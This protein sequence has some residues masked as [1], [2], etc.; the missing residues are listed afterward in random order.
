[1][2]TLSLLIPLYFLLSTS[3]SPMDD[4]TLTIKKTEDFEVS[5]EGKAQAWQ[6][7]DWI[8]IPQRE[9]QNDGWKTQAKI[10]YSD[11]GIYFLM[12]CEDSILTATLEEDFTNLYNEDV[13]EV[14]LWTDESHPVYFEYEISPLNY[15]LPIMVPNLGDDFFGWLPWHYE[16]ERKTRHATSVQGGEKKSGAT[17][18]GWTAEFFI[19]YALL[20][21][22][23]NVPPKKGTTWRANLYRI[24]YD[25]T[26]YKT[27]QWQLTSGSFHEYQTYG[28][29]IFD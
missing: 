7:T 24:D 16:G 13:V 26:E 11:K 14:F 25:E 22:L 2:K 20:K 15:E 18:S 23:N 21:P 10:L 9:G 1:L 19:P 28:T 8:N 3:F 4:T 27:W 12:Q 5:G 29:L 17:V 6:K